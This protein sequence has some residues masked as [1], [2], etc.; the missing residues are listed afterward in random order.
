LFR[1]EFVRGCI[2]IIAGLTIWENLTRLLLEDE[3][4]IPPPSSVIR[5]FWTLSLHGHLTKHFLAT[6]IEFADG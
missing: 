6:L 5:S 3:L 4:L 1:K 2:S